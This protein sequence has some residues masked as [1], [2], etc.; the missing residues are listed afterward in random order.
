MLNGVLTQMEIDVKKFEDLVSQFSIDSCDQFD[1]HKTQQVFHDGL[2]EA[3]RIVHKIK[4]RK[5][6]KE[7]QERL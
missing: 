4:T 2:K 7:R 5:E 1:F 3:E 6:E